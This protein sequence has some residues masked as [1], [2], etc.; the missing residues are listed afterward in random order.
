MSHMIL[1]EGV[2]KSYGKLHVL[3]NLCV[4]VEEG[5]VVSLIGPSGSGKSTALRCINGLESID[6]GRV[7]VDGETVDPQ[8]PT[9]FRLRSRIGFVFQSFNLFPHLR[10]IE[11]ITLA[12]TKVLKKP[13]AECQAKAYELLDQIGLPDKAQ[14]YP[15]ELS[16]GQRQRVA[17]ARALAMEPR[18]VLLDEITSALD[19]V[20]TVEVLKTV[21]ILAR[22]GMT[23]VIVTHEMAFAR[24]ISDRVVFLQAGEIVEEGPAEAMFSSPKDPRTRAFLSSVL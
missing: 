18:V 3:K 21:E 1:M 13:Q 19:P 20:L 17:I 15:F 8:S 4:H 22:A 10:V 7:V 23:M 24:R 12:P 2:N 9:I 6:S 5:E 11:N 16:G 14:S